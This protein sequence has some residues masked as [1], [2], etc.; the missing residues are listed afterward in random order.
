[1]A[2]SLQAISAALV[3]R[4]HH[5]AT[6]GVGSSVS[7]LL[8]QVATTKPDV[9][10]NLCEGFAGRAAAEAHFA[11]LLELLGIPY[12]GSGP[13]TLALVRQKA[14]TKWLL[15]GAGLSTP[16]FFVVSARAAADRSE[17]IRALEQG[18]LFL[19]PASEDASLGIGYDSIVSDFDSLLTKLLDLQTRY[20]DVLVERFIDGREFNVGVIALPEPTLLPLAE[21]KFQL[22]PTAPRAIVTYDAK[23][24]PGT[25][26]YDNTPVECPAQIG[27]ALANRIGQLALRAFQITGCRDYAR[28]DLRVNASDEVFIL[29]V[30]PNPDLSPEAGFA[31]ELRA[32]EITYAEFAEKLIENA[33]ARQAK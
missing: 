31:R 3:E 10:V 5:V 22:S 28:I 21:I 29:E 17:L 8:D 20:G 4:H 2:D 24:T 9:I 1:M 33:V 11:G 12:T 13:E 19:K 25:S 16:E 18:P 27:S 7:E 30:N 14:L 26:G 32:A 6:C 15:L 23:W